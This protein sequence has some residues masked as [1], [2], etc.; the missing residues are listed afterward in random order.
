MEES[1]EELKSLLMGLQEVSE[2]ADLKPNI[3]KTKSWLPVPLLHG[4]EKGEKWKKWKI[5]F[6]RAPKSLQ[7]MTVAMK[8]RRLLLGR[9][10]KT[11]IDSVLKSLC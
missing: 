4:K 3:K 9:K 11:N 6:S 10:A 8:L 2:K 7:T 5:L 1:E